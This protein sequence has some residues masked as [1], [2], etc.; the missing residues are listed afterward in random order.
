MAPALF[1][2][3]LALVGVPLAMT[4]KKPARIF[5][6]PF[7]MAFAFAMFIVPQAFALI[8]FPGFVEEGSVTAVLAMSCFSMTACFLGYQ[9][10]PSAAMLHLTSRPVDMK[11]LFRVG[12]VFVAMGYSMINIL[13]ATD[14][15]YSETGGMT[16]TA[17]ILL[18]F[19]LLAYPG[20]AIALFCALRRP[21]FTTIAMSLIGLYPL[22]KEAVMGRR[23]NTA[24][25]ALTVVMSFFYEGA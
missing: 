16:G 3:L 10:A 23:E 9:L 24:I 17:T 21:S 5:E 19:Q 6:Y 15:Q 18:F 11:R 2:V 25:L 20:F 1:I 4:M 14:V 12:I 13:S 7:F 22:L 8:R